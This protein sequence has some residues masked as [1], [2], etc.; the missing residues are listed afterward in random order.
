MDRKLEEK[1][2][3]CI[4][5]ASDHNDIDEEWVLDIVPE[6]KDLEAETLASLLGQFARHLR[7]ESAA[8]DLKAQALAGADRA[9]IA[10]VKWPPPHTAAAAAAITTAITTS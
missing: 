9:H 6:L 10:E 7:Y 1:L 8:R 2:L 4:A 3:R 5:D